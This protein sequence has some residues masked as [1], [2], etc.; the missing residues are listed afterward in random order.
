[1]SVTGPDGLEQGQSTEPITA[2][3]SLGYTG[4]QTLAQMLLNRNSVDAKAELFVKQGAGRWVKLGEYQIE[5]QLRT[6]NGRTRICTTPAAC[7]IR[8]CEG[9]PTSSSDCSSTRGRST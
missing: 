5:R 3:S 4:P 1:M 9:M 8:T 7:D 6:S 2:R